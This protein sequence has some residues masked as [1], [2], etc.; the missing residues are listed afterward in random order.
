[1]PDKESRSKVSIDFS[2]AESILEWESSQIQ[3]VEP[4]CHGLLAKR[5]ISLSRSLGQTDWPF[6]SLPS[7]IRL[8][9]VMIPRD[10]TTHL[11]CMRLRKAAVW[12]LFT[13]KCKLNLELSI[14]PSAIVQRKVCHFLFAGVLFITSCKKGSVSTLWTECWRSITQ[15]VTDM[16]TEVGRNYALEKGDRM[17]PR[18]IFHSK[19]FCESLNWW[20]WTAFS[21]SSSGPG[22]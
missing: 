14:C 8:P 18:G 10:Q 11:L 1:M 22:H 7:Q 13:K 16:F 15:Q 6:Q 19:L 20:F 2:R 21:L 9:T 4:K 3:C 12:M 17:A 5:V